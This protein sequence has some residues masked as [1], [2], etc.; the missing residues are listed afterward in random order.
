[1]R[2]LKAGICFLDEEDNVIS[3]RV[4]GT[5]WTI[6]IE[7]HLKDNFNVHILDEVAEIIT[8]NLKLQLN[9]SEVRKM[10]T[11]VEEREK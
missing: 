5:N 8:E 9:A 10:I 7:Q 1:M 11:E 2:T 4:I 6:D 3:K